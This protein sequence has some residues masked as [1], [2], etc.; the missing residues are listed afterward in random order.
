[1]NHL[2]IGLSPTLLEESRRE[3]ER[4]RRRRSE[5]RDARAARQVERTV[6]FAAITARLRHPLRPDPCRP[7][8]EGC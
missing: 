1:M 2:E 5:I 3:L 4:E 7:L 6:R 8:V